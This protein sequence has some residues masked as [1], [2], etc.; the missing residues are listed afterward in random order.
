M[1]TPQTVL[2]G[3]WNMESLHSQYI[4]HNQQIEAKLFGLKE[5]RSENQLCQRLCVRPDGIPIELLCVSKLLL[6]Q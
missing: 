6:D 4:S 5:L 3:R 2:L 1:A